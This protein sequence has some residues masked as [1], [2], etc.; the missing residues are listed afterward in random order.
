M[1]DW[2]NGL[3]D[4]GQKTAVKIAGFVAAIGPVFMAVGKLSGGFGNLIKDSGKL[5]SAI[6]KL[7]NGTKGFGAFKTI[8]TGPVGIALAGIATAALL[9]YKNWDKIGPIVKKA[10]DRFKE[11]GHNIKVLLGPEIETIKRIGSVVMDVFG[12]AFQAAF[13]IAGNLITNFFNFAGGMFNAFMTTLEGVIE[14]IKGVF[15]G[16]WKQAWEGVKSIF[17]GIWEGF[18]SIVK[19]PLNAVIGVLNGFIDGVNGFIDGL[20]GAVKSGI[21]GLFG[22]YHIP[23]IPQLAKGT[24]NWR[25]G[26]AQVHERGGEIIDLPRGTRV[27][28]HDESIQMARAEGEKTINITIP[29][30]A[31]YF[32]VR[33]EA[34][35]KRIVDY[36]AER[37]EKTS[38]N[39]A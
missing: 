36:L 25:G 2:W 30:L 28:P 26:I 1:V 31:D 21:E 17:R 8:M 7:T 9:I 27:Y 19:A 12:G 22:S 11:F 29:K 39:M 3:G 6:F 16:N 4:A 35:M 34:D 20:P 33:E 18:S 14:F 15:T 10:V 24:D 5:G 38:L 32:V 23:T 13:S 37:L